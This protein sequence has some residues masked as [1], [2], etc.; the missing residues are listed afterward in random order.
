MD[1]P[2]RSLFHGSKLLVQRRL[3]YPD[4]KRMR[5]IDGFLTVLQCKALRI[6]GGVFFAALAIWVP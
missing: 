3:P 5:L 6:T 4:T 1:V 2:F